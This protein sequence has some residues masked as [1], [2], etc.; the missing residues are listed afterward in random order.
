MNCTA[1]TPEPFG[2]API[3]AMSYYLPVISSNI[4][5][6][7]DFILH[8]ENGYLVEPTTVHQLAYYLNDLIGDPVKCER[9]GK[10]SAEIAQRYTWD[11]VGKLMREAIVERLNLPIAPTLQ[12]D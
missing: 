7:P 11:N 8:D 2:I 4:G 10:R 12:R 5:A 1:R 3:E 9:F 6:M